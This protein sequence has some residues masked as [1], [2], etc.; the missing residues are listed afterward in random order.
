[1]SKF[2]HVQRS[3]HSVQVTGSKRFNLVLKKVC[4]CVEVVC[5]GDV[6]SNMKT[7]NL[8]FS[9]ISGEFLLLREVSLYSFYLN[10]L[11]KTQ[12]KESLVRERLFRKFLSL[13]TTHT[14]NG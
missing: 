11:K 6:K 2:V 7:S 5:K 4:N 14:L 10:Y 12:N 1:M 3:V 9:D 13:W 8:K